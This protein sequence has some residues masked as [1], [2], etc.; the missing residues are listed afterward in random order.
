MSTQIKIFLCFF[1]IIT[2]LSTWWLTK[3]LIKPELINN[4]RIKKMEF[5]KPLISDRGL[6]GV[7]DCAIEIE[8]Y[9]DKEGINSF[10][11]LISK[12]ND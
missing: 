7:I 11:L 10:S 8:F 4:F 5:E 3:E 9:G 6:I 1:W 2:I 12:L